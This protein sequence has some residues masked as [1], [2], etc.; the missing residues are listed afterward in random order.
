VAPFT[1]TYGEHPRNFGIHPSGKWLL[2]AN[3]VPTHAVVAAVVMV[4]VVG[5][6][7]V[8]VLLL[9]LVL[10]V[11]LLELHVAADGGR[12]ARGLAGHQHG[13]HLQPRPVDRQPREAR[14]PR[15]PKAALRQVGRHGWWQNL[16]STDGAQLTELN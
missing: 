2:A 15:R 14:G 11:L 6:V 1:P 4:L 5:V 7:V 13:G 3:Q 9:L 12:L 10:L 16:N 8:L